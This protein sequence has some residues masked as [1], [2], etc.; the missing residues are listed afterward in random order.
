MGDFL[1]S[2]IVIIL[3]AT[4]VAVI[5]ILTSRK[6][7]VREDTMQQLAESSG[8]KYEKV[9]RTN[10]SGFILSTRDWI[11]EALNTSSDSPGEAGSSGITFANTWRSTRV[12]SPAGVVLIGSKMPSIN[13]GGLGELVFQKALQLMLGAEADQA[14]GLEEVYVGRTSFRDRFSVWA[15][16]RENAAHLLTYQL[17]N[18]LLNWKFKDIPVIKFSASGVMI[19]SRQEQLDT[20]EKVLALVN[21]GR[22]VLGD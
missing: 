13:L 6:K 3:V 14:V 5:F 2:I 17:E 21:L 19:I 4:A 11:L 1:V 9:K 15:T 18:A 22:A 8:W 20:P 10:Q 16:D 7:Q 12:K